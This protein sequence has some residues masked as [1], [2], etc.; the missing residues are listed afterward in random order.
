MK[1]LES[2][3]LDKDTISKGSYLRIAIH[4]GFRA[5]KNTIMKSQKD[6]LHLDYRRFDTSIF[7]AQSRRR[8]KLKTK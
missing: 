1:L 2:C 3:T 4:A 8:K 6:D 5:L 7:E